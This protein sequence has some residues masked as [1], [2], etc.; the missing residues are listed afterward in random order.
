MVCFFFSVEESVDDDLLEPL[1]EDELKMFYF[2]PL[3]EQL[4]GFTERFI[5]VSH[6]H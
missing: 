3:L 4:E 2:N 6:T 5:Y 1:S